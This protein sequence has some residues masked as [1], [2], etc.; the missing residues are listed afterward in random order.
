MFIKSE[1]HSVLKSK[2]IL[3]GQY[4]NSIKIN[5]VLKIF[6]IKENK[7]NFLGTRIFQKKIY[8]KNF[9]FKSLFFYF[10]NYGNSLFKSFYTGDS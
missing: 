3:V 9:I 1:K 6:E 7:K 4:H 10:Y 8:F 2:R 5:F